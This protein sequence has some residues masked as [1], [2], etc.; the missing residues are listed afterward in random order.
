M[1]KSYNVVIDSDTAVSGPNVSNY[2]YNFNWDLLE[3]GAYEL[4]FSFNSVGTTGTEPILITIENL[5]VMT[6]TFR[7]TASTTAYSS[8]VIGIVNSYDNSDATSNI[9]R[10][11]PND[12]AAVYLSSRPY[13]NTFNIKIT[14]F[15]QT[16]Y[17]LGVE[18][19]LILHLEKI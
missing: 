5:G 3:E 10:S 6:N 2:S 19:T 17:N 9:F 8:T 1:G 7:T 18:Y 16:L 4:T 13:S 15:D 11:A 14:R 12:N